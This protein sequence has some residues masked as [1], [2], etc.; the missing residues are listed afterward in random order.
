MSTPRL[1]PSF[2]TEVTIDAY[3]AKD[4]CRLLSAVE[5]F[6]RSGPV[7]AAVE[8]A[9]RSGEHLSANGLAEIAY[10]LRMRLYAEAEP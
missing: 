2:P 5:R 4:I 10:E 9:S 1:E 3:T 7:E 8:L 6:A